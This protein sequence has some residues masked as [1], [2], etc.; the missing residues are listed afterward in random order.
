MKQ[1]RIAIVHLLLSEETFINMLKDDYEVVINK[2]NPDI[3]FHDY[4]THNGKEATEICK[5]QCPKILYTGESGKVD[6]NI[7]DYAFSL[8]VTSSRNQ[9]IFRGVGRASNATLALRE[10]L[11]NKLTP[12]IRRCQT[13]SKKKF[14]HFIY[15]QEKFFGA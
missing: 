7:I 9:Q 14:C 1:L 5:Y 6:Y 13:R 10:L 8:N 12:E 2:E 11:E 3:L 15:R 4:L